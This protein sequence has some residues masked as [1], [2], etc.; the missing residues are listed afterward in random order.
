MS[1]V[2]DA[3]S[4]VMTR[5]I[6]GVLDLEGTR[7][8]YT[9]NGTDMRATIPEWTPLNAVFSYGADVVVT[10]AATGTFQNVVLGETATGEHSI[11][12]RSTGELQVVYTDRTGTFRGSLVGL[13]SDGEKLTIE[14][15]YYTDRVEIFKNGA[16]STTNNNAPELA[17]ISAIAANLVPNQFFGGKISNVFTKSTSPIQN[18]NAM[19]GNGTDRYASIPTFSPV[20]FTSKQ[21]I[22]EDDLSSIPRIWGRLQSVSTSRC[23]ITANGSVV[24]SDISGNNLS[25]SNFD[26][27]QGR[28]HYLETEVLADGSCEIWVDGVSQASASAGAFDGLAFDIDSVHRAGTSTSDTSIITNQVFQDLTTGVVRTYN[29]TD[30]Y[31]S[32]GSVILPD[33]TGGANGIWVNAT[34]GDLQYLPRTDRRYR[35]DDGVIPTIADSRG[36][37]AQDGTIING[38]SAN[39]NR[40]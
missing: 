7:E 8:F 19:A 39:Y 3:M 36:L 27:I 18:V 26:I 21:W 1:I 31:V 24:L 37:P 23:I 29:N 22:R 30:N 15:K 32:G 40:S 28:D 9:F 34:I 17:S 25:T 2:T 16:L 13:L 11:R 4:E 6:S 5:P 35:I 38:N 14:V 20:A 12:I 33:S 10:T